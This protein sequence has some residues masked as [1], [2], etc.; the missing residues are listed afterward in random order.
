MKKGNKIWKALA[1]SSALL[2]F[3]ALLAAL[4]TLGGAA[5]V[6]T[7]T[8][9]VTLDP[10]KTESVRL[11]YAP[12]GD[13]STS[14]NVKNA[15]VTVTDGKYVFSGIED[16]ADVR[17]YVLTKPG[18]EC[19]T[20]PVT[21][22]GGAIS[23]IYLRRDTTSGEHVFSKEGYTQDASFTVAQNARSSYQ[24]EFLAPS[25]KPLNYTVEGYNFIGRE[26]SFGTEFLLP[27]SVTL[28]NAVF[29]EQWNVVANP[30]GDVLFTVTEEGG[31][32]KIPT[33]IVT[34]Q[35]AEA[36]KEAHKNNKLYVYPVFL[37]DPLPILREDYVMIGG[38]MPSDKTQWI[39]LGEGTIVSD[40][41][42]IR[43]YTEKVTGIGYYDESE[44]AAGNRY[45]TYRGFEVVTD[46]A[47]YRG[48]EKRILN[49]TDKIVRFYKPITY[50]LS[51]DTDNDQTLSDTSYVYST[52]CTLKLPVKWG[53]DFLGF[54]VTVKINN[55]VKTYTVEE[56][57]RDGNTGL[58]TYTRDSEGRITGAKIVGGTQYPE[59]ASEDGKMTL[60]A[61]WA[62]S[63]CKIEYVLDNV[64]EEADQETNANLP[65]HFIHKST[66]VLGAKQIEI[67]LPKRSGYVFDHW[68]VYY[69]GEDGSFVEIPD[70]YDRV[71]DGERYTTDGAFF[72]PTDTYATDVKLEPYWRAMG[73]TVVFDVND[74]ATAV[75]T[76]YAGTASLGGRVFVFD[77]V[78]SLDGFVN[79]AMPVCTGYE[80]DGYWSR[81]EGGKQYITSEGKAVDGVVWTEYETDGK[82]N[83]VL[84]AH[85]TPKKYQVSFDLD[86]SLLPMGMKKED[87]RVFVQYL[88]SFGED[89]QS[90][91]DDEWSELV[92]LSEPAVY[93]FGTH[94]RFRVECPEGYKT[95]SLI[96]NYT[97]EMK[98]RIHANP[99]LSETQILGAYPKA[100][101][102]VEG[103]EGNMTF[104]VRICPMIN[105]L[106]SEELGKIRESIDY[107]GETFGGFPE[108]AYRVSLGDEILEITVENGIIKET[109]KEYVGILN[110]FFGNDV[111][112][113]R[114]GDGISWADSAPVTLHFVARPAAPE[115]DLFVTDSSFEDRLSLKLADGV[116]LDLSLYEFAVSHLS[117]PALTEGLVW[118]DDPLALLRT[119]ENEEDAVRPGTAYYVLVRLK[120]TKKAP[121]G[122]ECVI[123]AA[124]TAYKAYLDGVYAYLDGIHAAGGENTKVLVAA[125]K[126]AIGALVTATESGIADGS[127][128]M[129]RISVYHDV[130]ALLGVFETEL[131][132]AKS[133]DAA[134]ATLEAFIKEGA[135]GR[136]YTSQ[137]LSLLASYQAAALP[138]IRAA[139]T[140]GEVDTYLSGA[141]S[142]MRSVA[143]C[144]V[145]DSTQSV[146][147]ESERGI[148]YASVLTLLEQNPMDEKLLEGIR[149]A[150]K[151]GRIA[152]P[153]GMDE[154]EAKS[155]LSSLDVIAYYTFSLE[156]A[157][158]KKGD[159]LTVRLSIPESIREESG[160]RVGY[161]DPDTKELV[162]LASDEVTRDGDTLVFYASYIHDFAIFADPTVS[163]TGFV[164]ALAILLVCQLAAIVL[165]LW[166]FIQRKRNVTH[167]SIA[168][169][170]IALAVKFAPAGAETALWIMGILAMLLQAVIVLLILRLRPVYVGIGARRTRRKDL[171]PIGNGEDD[172]EDEELE[173]EELEQEDEDE[174]LQGEE[175]ENV[176]DFTDEESSTAPFDAEEDGEDSYEAL[177]ATEAADTASEE[178][179]DGD[180]RQGRIFISEDGEVFYG[181]EYEKEGMKEFTPLTEEETDTALF[182]LEDEALPA[183]TDEDEDAMYKYD[184]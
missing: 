126:E 40:D 137:N 124:P 20:D 171:A 168:L 54:E 165:L 111:E 125:T 109:G 60:R 11:E 19:N 2:L 92:S 174:D 32:Y 43:T 52:D 3:S 91:K 98:A 184:E 18:Y 117:D 65:T 45:K 116:T 41:G 81:P 105:A 143:R 90:D 67:P 97:D 169:P 146:R 108:G 36:M 99:F 152:F 42:G 179:T 176:E 100:D 38:T 153:E 170:V 156:N 164:W 21:A 56:A 24:L 136:L 27:S 44:I 58:I 158:L 28:P 1:V 180:S 135:D 34:A 151:A 106:T 48:Y 113:Y 155:L 148:P 7:H 64:T 55:R 74:A 147:V 138:L 131:L 183:D 101:G 82:G 154:K 51:Y 83:V 69:K 163:L 177:D 178:A 15:N 115:K 132:L 59:F 13:W 149:A 181:D 114:R 16:G 73:Y 37:G 107:I 103:R 173:Q 93:D 49:A 5:S 159:R 104:G 157:V 35:N 61:T 150:I 39:K 175:F 78:F 9:T 96:R 77:Q 30:E 110:A 14:S 29:K 161:Y 122:N 129:S 10:D 4:L 102:T 71:S 26:Y 62:P 95:V 142:E 6:A 70:V 47:L 46:P 80:F 182:D 12:E 128:D 87:V 57:E 75:T 145:F 121:H 141:L 22:D 85:W 17:L 79:L 112:V 72:L 66:D 144:A 94:F 172:V 23:L 88:V 127:A 167:A 118:T 33:E 120:A 76:P 140:E 53:F 166:N 134:E 139:Q 160:L 63:K 133:K 25:R 84:Y 31:A 8:L 162:L 50:K 68:S 89:L 86:R 130:E 119:G 123:L